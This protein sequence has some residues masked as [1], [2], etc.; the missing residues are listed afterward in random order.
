M[1]HS[2]F[3]IVWK[4]WYSLEQFVEI[5]EIL[6]NKKR[7]S[8]ITSSWSYI[9]NPQRGTSQTSAITHKGE[10]GSVCVVGSP[11]GDWEY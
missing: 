11:F 7:A 10:N 5:Y 4:T 2:A 3:C 6:E 1:D 8:K 9:S